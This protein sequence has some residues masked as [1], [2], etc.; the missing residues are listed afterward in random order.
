MNKR[1]HIMRHCRMM[2]MFSY[3]VGGVTGEG[4][5]GSIQYGGFR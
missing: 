1:V 4:G 2:C 5:D 3:E